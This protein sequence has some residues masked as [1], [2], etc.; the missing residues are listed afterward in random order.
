MGRVGSTLLP[1]SIWS[2]PLLYPYI[3][4]VPNSSSKPPDTWNLQIVP[5]SSADPREP[6]PD[7]SKAPFEV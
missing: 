3:L 6:N 4:Y 1:H 5:L 2:F 7:C